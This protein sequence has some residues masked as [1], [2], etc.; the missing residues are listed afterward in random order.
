[1]IQVL[2]EV[3]IAM[4]T[5]RIN[6]L[7]EHL[8]NTKGLSFTAGAVKNGRERRGLLN[9]LRNKSRKDIETLLQN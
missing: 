9:Y 4:L 6:Q 8:R 3:Q 5:K 1:M 7:T 2:Q